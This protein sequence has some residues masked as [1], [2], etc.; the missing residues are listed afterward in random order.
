MKVCI[1]TE[2]GKNIGFGHL[3]RCL[4]L[5]DRLEKAGGS[6]RIK[7]IIKG[8]K[9]I[10]DVISEDKYI[11]L[12]WQNEENKLLEKIKGADMAIVDS[13]LAETDF[14]KKISYAVRTMVC[15]DD[16]NRLHDPAGRVRN[17]MRYAG[18]LDDPGKKG[19]TYLLGGRYAILRKEFWNIPRRDIKPKM[20]SIMITF[21]GDDKR[22]LTTVILKFLHEKF[23]HL[24]KNV[25][26]GKAFVNRK[27][28]EGM[29]E[30]RTN[31]I[32]NPDAG[33][34][35]DVML[36]SDLAVSAGGQTLQ[37]L[38]RTGLPAIGICVADNQERNLKAWHKAGFA[39][40]IGWHDKKDLLHK[41]K[42]AILKLSPKSERKKRSCIG[43]D[44]IDG[45]GARRII[46]SLVYNKVTV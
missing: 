1:I 19:L 43:A 30:D 18:E 3:V 14:Y 27:E 32:F 24:K 35:K 8:D 13:Y 20:E 31:L 15:I 17:G 5:A 7:F 9:S 2:G 45:E 40:Y 11:I 44:K 25:I 42:K 33:A 12:N 26:I 29:K 41:A 39:E 23:P 38:A 37:E 46:D 36:Q 21:G 22:G 28:I 16:N 4:A 10:S 34:I 6:A